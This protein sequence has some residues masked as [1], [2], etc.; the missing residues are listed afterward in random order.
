MQLKQKLVYM[1]VGSLFT[2][3]GFMLASIVG[4][5]TAQTK[6]A[7]VEFDTVT[8][9]SLRIVDASGQIR[10]Q[11]DATSEGGRVGI[12]NKKGKV[13]AQM[14]VL[15]NMGTVFVSDENGKV[16]N[17]MPESTSRNASPQVIAPTPPLQENADQITVY[18]TR[19]GKKY[20]QAGCRY[21]SKSQIPMSLKDAK[22]RY[23][24]CSV[25]N[26]PQ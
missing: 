5:V 8:C 6:K 22:A 25:C 1:A 16:M 19:T 2:L 4:D 26:P 23:S 17:A 21:L 12:F 20:H 15:N 10:A 14:S 18:I 24:P 3:L 9:Q 11:I 7:S 13:S